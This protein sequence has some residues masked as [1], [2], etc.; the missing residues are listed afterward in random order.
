MI[1]NI[2][3]Q[4]NMKEIIL[5]LR[6]NEEIICKVKQDVNIRVIYLNK[7]TIDKYIDKFPIYFDKNQDP[8]ILI[9]DTINFDD[10]ETEEEKNMLYEIYE[11]FYYNIFDHIKGYKFFN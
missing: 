3:K 6:T 2:L 1:Y 11:Q 4:N 10:F 8:F 5:K 7:N 9:M